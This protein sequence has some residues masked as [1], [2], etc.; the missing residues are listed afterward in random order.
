[1]LD[2]TEAPAEGKNGR[3]HSECDDIGKRIEL[4]A[5]FARCLGE[6]G[7]AAVEAVKNISDADQN[8]RPV[9]VAGVPI[10]AQRP[11][12]GVVTAENVADR[13]KAG[14]DR[15]TAPNSSLI[16]NSSCPSHS[17]GL[18]LMMPIGVDPPRTR[19]PRSTVASV[20]AGKSTSTRD[21]NR[22]SPIS[23]PFPTVS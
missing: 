9:P 16:L 18:S 17:F 14:N 5:E 11:D 23:S 1:A 15:K 21:P 4:Y 6:S 13:K 3:S 10:P 20:P 19:A 7:D 12:D 8:R 2:L 22:M